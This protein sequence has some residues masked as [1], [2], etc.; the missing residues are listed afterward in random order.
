MTMSVAFV[1]LSA[2]LC[3]CPIP[4]PEHIWHALFYNLLVIY[5]FIYNLLFTQIYK[6]IIPFTLFK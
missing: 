4:D 5:L 3:L 2:K 6:Y 1:H